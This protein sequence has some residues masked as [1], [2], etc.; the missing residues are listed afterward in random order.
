MGSIIAF[1]RGNGF[2][3]SSVDLRP[4]CFKNTD[5]P[6]SLFGQLFPDLVITGLE[7]LNP[8]ER[9]TLI[10]AINHEYDWWFR[11][12]NTDAKA[13]F[14]K[15]EYEYGTIDDENDDYFRMIGA[16]ALALLDLINHCEPPCSD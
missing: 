7:A 9:V 13:A 4:S 10:G 2:D 5:V 6:L 12:G 3:L 15:I 16:F 8:I 14:P 1:D 11:D